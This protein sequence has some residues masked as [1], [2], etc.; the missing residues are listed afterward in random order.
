MG[1]IGTAS[2]EDVEGLLQ[3]DESIIFH[4]KGTLET[5]RMGQKAKRTYRVAV[6]ERRLLAVDKKALGGIDYQEVM[7]DKI[8]SVDVSQ[9]PMNLSRVHLAASGD[10][11]AV[12]ML[13]KED[14]ALLGDAVRKV[15]SR[16][17][18]PAAGADLPA[19]LARLGELRDAGTLTPEEFEAAKRRLLG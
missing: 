18:A 17:A 13:S 11:I 14:A 7:L 4:C 2:V 1:V 8:S 15:A 9:R 5:R 6:T 19:Q 10:S 16:A 12:T 3:P